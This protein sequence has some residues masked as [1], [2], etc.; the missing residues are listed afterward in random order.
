MIYGIEVELLLSSVEK[1]STME[2]P[3]FYAPV[4]EGYAPPP[5]GVE[6]KNFLVAGMDGIGPTSAEI[7]KLDAPDGMYHT[8]AKI[9]E[10]EIT[11][12]Y[13]YDP[14]FS[15]GESVTSLRTE[16]NRFFPPSRDVKLTFH[17]DHFGPV[18]TVGRVESIEANHMTNTPLT[19]IIILCPNYYYESEELRSIETAYNHNSTTSYRMWNFLE[20][21][22]D[23]STPFKFN[24]EFPRV[25]LVSSSY[26]VLGLDTF[27]NSTSPNRLYPNRIVVRNQ[28]FDALDPTN[29]YY[30]ELDLNTDRKVKGLR[31]RAVYS[32]ARSYYDLI[33]YAAFA[34]EWFYI[35]PYTTR[36]WFYFVNTQLDNTHREVRYTAEYRE[37]F[38]SL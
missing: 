19:Q 28:F 3:R 8:G 7:Q 9:N 25:S 12:T 21:R 29:S 38:S 13:A 34:P 30:I 31:G 36:F 10:R 15:R 24:V 11:L 1:P 20:Y 22:G 27:F 16:I 26:L 33:D 32:S 14:D 4:I 5:A 37:R 23:V 6:V 35:S 17:T 2:N 18:S